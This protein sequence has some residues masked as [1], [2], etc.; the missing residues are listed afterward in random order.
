[1]NAFA[2]VSVVSWMLCSA[3]TQILNKLLYT[4]YHFRFPLLLTLVHMIVNYICSLVVLKWLKIH[5]FMPLKSTKEYVFGAFPLAVVFILNI[6]FG[7]LSLLHIHVSFYQV[8]KASTPFFTV[9]LQFIL[10]HKA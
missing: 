9:L 4:S 8:I 3:F 2:I 6:V 5:P 7:N 1:M 10:L